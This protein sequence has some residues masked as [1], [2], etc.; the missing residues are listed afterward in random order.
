MQT[1]FKLRV[2]AAAMLQSDQLECMHREA[3]ERMIN[4]KLG[5]DAGAV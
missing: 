3:L 4:V 2:G 1:P 5:S